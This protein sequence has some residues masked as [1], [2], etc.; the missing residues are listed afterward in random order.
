MRIY[1]CDEP[2]LHAVCK[3]VAIEDEEQMS[4]IRAMKDE[5]AQL[6]YDTNGCGLAAPQIG[7]SYRF[8]V[9]DCEWDV[10]T[11]ENKNPVMMINP[12]I[13]ESSGEHEKNAEGCLS[14]PGVSIVVERPTE[15]VF[16]Y[17][18]E[19][20][21]YHQ[22]SASGLLSRCVQH[23]IDHLDGI[24]LVEK[25]KGVKRMQALAMLNAAKKQGIEPGN[26]AL[27]IVR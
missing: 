6:M 2:E 13:V 17:Y 12:V 26:E 20:G 11:G 14:V 4:S 24:T 3:P 1:T 23:E 25:T 7:E 27:Y 21:E 16:G 9:I 5:M 18:D 10:E 22:K 8:V 15:I 19:N